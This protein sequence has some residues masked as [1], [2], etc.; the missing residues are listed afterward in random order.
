M[1]RWAAGD[2]EQGCLHHG[3]C[4]LR[5]RTVDRDTGSAHRGTDPP[6]VRDDVVFVRNPERVA[7]GPFETLRNAFTALDAETADWDFGSFD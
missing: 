4:W 3:H 2:A 7:D 5:A 1:T 6:L